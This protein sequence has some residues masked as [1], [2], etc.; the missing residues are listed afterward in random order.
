[1]KVQSKSTAPHRRRQPSNQTTRI[2][3]YAIVFNS[4]HKVLLCRLS[5]GIPHSGKWTLP[6][7]GIEFGEDLQAGAAREV[8]EETGLTVRVT[9]VLDAHSELFTYP[10]RQAQAVRVIFGADLESGDIKFEENGST[11]M[12]AFFSLDELEQLPCVDLVFRSIQLIRDR[13]VT[14]RQ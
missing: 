3:C 8:F 7:G 5:N 4:E 6:G 11:D 2:A 1:M 10:E 12:C 14:L 13:L 9:G